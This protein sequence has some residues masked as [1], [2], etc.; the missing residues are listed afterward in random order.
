MIYG[1]WRMI[2]IKYT[3]NKPSISFTGVSFEGKQDK[4][5]FIEPL[6]RVVDKLLDSKKLDTKDK[7][8]D[9]LLNILYNLLPDFDKIYEEH[10]NIY[11]QKL[12]LE[13]QKVKEN[14]QLNHIEKET[15]RNNYKYMRDY[16][17]QR[18]TNK[19]VYE[20]IINTAV[21]L[22]KEK[23]IKNIK[24]IKT[25]LSARFLHVLESL[26]RTMDMEKVTLSSRIDVKLEKKD[27]YAQLS[28]V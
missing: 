2:Q 24:N 5:N 18:A 20:K 7:N 17:I 27:S 21:K 13:E 8:E 6:I 14:K 19:L 9:E 25:P 12:D 28:I 1:K 23:N 15:L 10:I 26:K 22:I 16:R 4:Y 11:K 3:G